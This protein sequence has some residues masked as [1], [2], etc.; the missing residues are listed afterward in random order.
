MSKPNEKDL[1]QKRFAS[2]QQFIS[3]TGLKIQARATSASGRWV[4][5]LGE[6]LRNG[7]TCFDTV[8]I[9]YEDLYI[10][11]HH[12]DVAEGERETYDTLREQAKA[13]ARDF[14]EQA[15][16]RLQTVTNTEEADEG[17]GLTVVNPDGSKEDYTI[18]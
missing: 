11:A 3:V 9:R 14:F 4:I 15:K 18:N 12:F 2:I 16:A 13:K 5:L 1:K 10:D 6:H 7:F 17:S 8:L